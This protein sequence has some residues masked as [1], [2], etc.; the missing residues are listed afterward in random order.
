MLSLISKAGEIKTALILITVVLVITLV[1]SQ[2]IRV[3]YPTELGNPGPLQFYLFVVLV[4]IA[5]FISMC[6]LRFTKRNDVEAR[7]SRP[8][9]FKTAFISTLCAQIAISLILFVVISEMLVFQGYHR[10]F[11][12]SVVYVSHLLPIFIL[13][14][15]S[16]TFLHWLRF[17]RSFSVLV[18]AAVFIVTLFLILITIPVLTE[19]FSLQS[20]IIQPRPYLILIQDYFVPSDSTVFSAVY[21]FSTYVLPIL[22]L[23]SWTLTVLL[24]KTF[25]RRI[26]KRKFWLIVSIPLA[27]QIFVIVASNPNL[28]TNPDMVQIVYSPQVQ[29]LINING[30]VSGLFFSAAFL[31]VGRKI[32]RESMKTFFVMSAIGIISLFCSIQPGSPFYAAYPPFGL[33]TLM[34]LGLSSYMLLVGM[35]GAAAYVSRN[36]DVRQEVY[37]SL[38]KDSAVLNM[39]LAEMQR[40]VQKRITVAFENIK[41]AD[42]S[43]EVKTSMAPD[44]EDVQL[45]IEDVLREV[46]STRPGTKNR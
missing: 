23:A 16:F 22:V 21:G 11:L 25:M 33:A 9:L 3:F 34:F 45:M 43:D 2:F 30:Q 6:L 32:R 41:S 10:V 1:D 19:Q 38:E 12:L 24:L 39:G 18:Y 36:S 37:K 15:L 44:E 28:I 8:V 5:S 46:H 27:Y 31:I 40:E 17:G 4:V 7:S 35:V 13:G 14:V 29:L 42:M 26:G 20:D